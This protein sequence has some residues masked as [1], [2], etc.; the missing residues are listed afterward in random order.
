MRR[1]IRPIVAPITPERRMLVSAFLLAGLLT[2][3]IMGYMFI[4]GWS[5]LDA[6]YMTVI[7][8][9]TVGFHEI[10]PLDNSG[11]IFTIFL[12]LLGVGVAFYILT[13]L[14]ALVVEGDLGLALGLRRMKG[15]IEALSDHYILCGFGRVGQEIARDLAARR[16]P[17]VIIDSNPE[18]IESARKQDCLL[19]EGDATSDAALIEAGIQRAQCLLAAS[20]S[21]TGNTYIVLTAKALNPGLFVVARVGQPA[22]TTPMLRAGADRV[23]SPYSIGGR[24]MALS[25]LQPLVVDFIDTLATGRHGEQILAELEA[26]EES[27]L[28]GMTI[29]KCFETCPGATVL[30]LQKASG[31]IQVGPRGTTVLELGDRLIVLGYEAELEALHPPSPTERAAT[32][33]GTAVRPDESAGIA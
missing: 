18:A 31:A 9:T 7:S 2:L 28:A 10:Q 3:G 20:D 16:V 21:D 12:I 26:S 17:F 6:L 22:S 29:K 24:R 8:I 1:P 19:V 27:G 32:D 25:A 11:R 30:A 13:A 14:V 4:E 15:K 33:K 23:I 5:F